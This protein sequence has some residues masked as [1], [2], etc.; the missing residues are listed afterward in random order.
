M[1]D[2]SAL[3]DLR[4]QALGD[5]TRRAVLQRLCVGPSSVGELAA[6]F[7]MALP[8]FMQ[9]LSLLERSG[10]IS[11]RKEG[12]VRTCSLNGDTLA[13]TEGWLSA[14]RA[15]W[16]QRLDQLDHYLYQLHEKEKKP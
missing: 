9:H 11:S 10:L 2:Q 16:A 1:S 3:L 4:F 6:P 13:Q 12:R 7:D 5:P 8:S 14:Q 15:L